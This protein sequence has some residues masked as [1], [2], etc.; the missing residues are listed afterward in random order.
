MVVTRRRLAWA[1]LAIVLAGGCRGRE[2][3]EYADALGALKARARAEGARLDRWEAAATPTGDVAD[4]G[5]DA[6][7][8][9]PVAADGPVALPLD[10]LAPVGV[11]LPA[12]RAALEAHAASVD[13][14]VTGFEA[15]VRPTSTEDSEA[16][17]T[18]AGPSPTAAGPA[19]ARPAEA[20]GPGPVPRPR[21]I[22]VVL[23]LAP[24]DLGRLERWWAARRRAVRRFVVDEV[25]FGKD[26]ATVR[27]TAW[28]LEAAP[29]PLDVDR[30]LREA[31]LP[32]EADGPEVR[33]L[34]ETFAALA[35]RRARLT[36]ARRLE[37]RR[38]LARDLAGR[39]AAQRWLDVL[40]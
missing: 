22:D 39:V 31:G 11:D 3:P 30:L 17:A 20:A 16:G 40:R 32:P 9:A 23:T 7:A 21:A 8:E 15:E 27:L 19:P 36:A 34:R 12:L 10:A 38:A 37:A 14:T 35:A 18:D 13:L 6:G 26:A 28:A 24:A 4:A 33:A 1:A 25:R 5:P 2:I 29:P